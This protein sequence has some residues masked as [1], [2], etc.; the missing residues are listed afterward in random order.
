MEM[1]SKIE[2]NVSLRGEK[3]HTGNSRHEF[4]SF[5][6]ARNAAPRRYKRY[7]NRPASTCCVLF[8]HSLSRLVSS[9]S[10]L[11]STFPYPN[12]LLRN[13]YP[14]ELELCNVAAAAKCGYRAEI[15]RHG[16]CA[17][18]IRGALQLFAGP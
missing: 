2:W 17:R 9:C 4:I 18:L 16:R 5:H 13:D 3:L 12:N 15:F 11:R 8:K 14:R 7:A 10:R 6:G 1:R